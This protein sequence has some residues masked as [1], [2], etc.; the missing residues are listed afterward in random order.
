M[1]IYVESNP[2]NIQVDLSNYDRSVLSYKR[3]QDFPAVGSP[4]PLY[5][6]EREKTLWQWDV[7]TQS[8]YPIAGKGILPY[9]LGST[10]KVENNTLNVNTASEV[11]EDNTLP[12]TSAAV[13]TEVGN[14]NAL[15]E[16]V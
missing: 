9:T 15:L 13:Y 5:K 10:L 16:T 8:Y 3:R 7:N 6:S 14:I 12:I 4:Y 1:S 11:E 2:N